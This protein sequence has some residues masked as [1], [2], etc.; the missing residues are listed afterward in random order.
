MEGGGPVPGEDPPNEAEPQFDPFGGGE[1]P[2]AED[3]P[4]GSSSVSGPIPSGE[5]GGRS[6]DGWRITG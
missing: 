1:Q 2:E 3:D 5:P 4:F 6:R